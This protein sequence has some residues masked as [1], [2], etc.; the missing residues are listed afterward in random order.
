MGWASGFRAGSDV[1][2]QA[3]DTYKEAKQ[4]RDFQKIAD[5]KPEESQG[6]TAEDGDQLTAIANARRPDG[7]PYY[8]VETN[9]EGGYG[10]RS[11]FTLPGADGQQ[12]QPGMV[13]MAP[14]TVTDFMDQRTA[15]VMDQRG[16]DNAR[17]GAYADAISQQD[18]VRGM[19]MRRQMSQDAREDTRFA[20]DAQRF[21]WEKDAQP[22]KQ[23]GAELGVKQ[24]ELQVG[25]LEDVK[26][27]KT[28]FGTA[29]K[30]YTGTPEQVKLATSQVNRMSASVT[31]GDRDPKTGLMR[32]S[33]VTGDGTS[34][35]AKLTDYEQKQL[36]A[37]ATMLG[38]H[39]MEA[40]KVMSAVNKDIAEAVARDNNLT[41]FLADNN[42]DI[43][44]KTD[45][46]NTNA[47]ELGLRA[48]SNSISA[49]NG[50]Q[51]R[52][53]PEVMINEKGE[54]VIVDI[55]ALPYGADGTS[56]LPQGLRVPGKSIS[57]SD[58]ATG[59]QKLVEAGLSLPQARMEMDARSG[60]GSTKP[61]A[62]NPDASLV[63]QQKAREAARAKPPGAATDRAPIP[64]APTMA[65]IQSQ[66]RARQAASEQMARDPDLGQMRQMHEQLIRAGRAVDANRVMQKMDEL[67][68]QRYGVN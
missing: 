64:P 50:R 44:S 37:G 32:M 17:Y 16:I 53:K 52:V 14:R 28:G 41:K 38:S 10:V 48:Q 66:F 29:L 59:V 55:N 22:L 12:T 5:A 25:E 56:T 49:A 34:I 65:E 30:E 20:Q 36:F 57:P 58:Y 24:A 2:R 11:N 7:T 43:A 19:Q 15:G 61:P 23:R 60:G 67:K 33:V 45:S 46:M 21:G 62:N 47:A 1:A 40:L 39:P 6:Y 31:L 26:N 42:N 54:T 35:F 9:P 51:A 8:S 63:D 27:F 13:G 3:I 4:Q 18:P 68:Q